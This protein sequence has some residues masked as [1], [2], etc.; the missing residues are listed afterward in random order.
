[1]EEI[2]EL[3]RKDIL[4]SE[5]PKYYSELDIF[6]LGRQLGISKDVYYSDGLVK[7]KIVENFVETVYRLEL[8]AELINIIKTKDK[9]YRKNILDRMESLLKKSSNESLKVMLNLS[10]IHLER[11]D[12]V[13]RYLLQL[14]TDLKSL[15]KIKRLDYIVISGD[16]TNRATINEFELA[17]QFLNDIIKS[18]EV[19]SN[20]VII[21]PGNHDLD[22]N[23]CKECVENETGAITNQQ[24]YNDKFKNFNDYFYQ[25][26]CDVQYPMDPGKQGVLKIF[27][28]DKIIFLELNSSYNIDHVN[29]LRSD[30]NFDSLYNALNIL[31]ENEKYDNY[32][33][34]AVFHHA[35]SG[36]DSMNDEFIEILI[37]NKFNIC[38]HGHIHRANYNFS[39]YDSKRGM[40]IIGS[41][42]FG[43]PT[44]QQVSGIPLQYNI[45]E[46]YENKVKVNTRKK[47]SIKGAWMADARWGEKENPVPY[48]EFEI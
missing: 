40:N 34:I 32:K 23:I 43:A 1:M 33:K 31:V 15:K 24:L 39:K 16:I 37:N 17:T 38:M 5:I 3:K 6:S 13:K 9:F 35:V 30:I 42:T 46:F 10:D 36:E 12:D 20:K 4:I 11:E 27:D 2:L 19:S 8:E 29:K 22:W 26:V 48:Y 7:L 41:G 44:N 28:D 25:S 14:K 45:I 47:E 18:F 21:V